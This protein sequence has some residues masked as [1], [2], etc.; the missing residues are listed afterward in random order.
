MAII[1]CKM[2]GGDLQVIEGSTV[3]ECEYCGTKQTVP[4]LDNEKKLTLFNRASRLL[5]N[6]EFD[7]AYGV[8]ESI[9]AEFPEEA[10][11][12]W[13]LCLCRYGIEYVDDPVT[14]KKIP[15]CHRTLSSSIMD[16]SDFDMACE[17]AD[18]VA[19]RLYR[20]E[21]KAIDRIQQSIL[22]I[23]AK[24]EPYDV[25]ICYKEL[26]ENGARTEDSVL[27][28]EIYDSLTAKG[29]KVFFSRITLES[30]LGEEYEP[31]IYAA[32]L[33][34]KVMLAVGTS[35]ENFDAVWVKNEWARFLNM[36]KK[37]PNKKL[38]PCFKGID[39]YDMPREFKNLLA[40]DMGKLGWQQDLTRGVVKICGK[41]GTNKAAKSNAA[42]S[43]ITALNVQTE[44]ML[45]RGYMML[46]DGEYEKADEFFEK[47]LN[48]DAE[49]GQAY[50]GKVLATAKVRN[51][52]E[53][54]HAF[55]FN[56][57][58]SQ[59]KPKSVILSIPSIADLAR[60][61]DES[62]LLKTFSDQ[63]LKK[64][65]MDIEYK[66]EQIQT[67]LHYFREQEK[68]F[69]IPAQLNDLASSRDFE[70]ADKY[71]DSVVQEGE[72]IALKS[73]R[74]RIAA[75]IS[76]E[77]K[78]EDDTKQRT[79]KQQTQIV[80]E[81]K[82]RL[83]NV[84][85]Y[86]EKQGDAIETEQRKAEKQAEED[87]QAALIE[88]EQHHQA[89]VDSLNTMYQQ[90]IEDWESRK[91]DYDQNHDS[92]VTEY[93][94]IQKEIT[95]VEAEK[96]NLHGLFTGK[97][98]REIEDKLTSLRRR[99]N[100]VVIP[101]DP[102]PKPLKPGEVQ[103]GEPPQRKDFLLAYKNSEAAALRERIMCSLSPSYQE[104]RAEKDK[105]KDKAPGDVLRFGSYPVFRNAKTGLVD[106]IVLE[107]K[108][109]RLLVISKY[110]ID[111]RF[112]YEEKPTNYQ[113]IRGIPWEKSN[114]RSWL[115]GSFLKT[116]FT[117]E[118]QEMIPTVT[119]SADMN[120]KKNT[121]PGR[122]TLDKIF[123]LSIPEVNQYFHS[124]A[125][126]K[127]IPTQY[128]RKQGCCEYNGTCWWWLRSPGDHRI[129]S[130]AG[131]DHDG[132]VGGGSIGVYCNKNAVRPAMWIKI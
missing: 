105:L 57:L 11:A 12:Y 19:K 46:E 7:K 5:R 85:Q 131:V 124:D 129:N 86:Y 58:K 64:L 100:D 109:N 68:R 28:Q 82:A 3:C 26:D 36:M 127:C 79:E 67:V 52:E 104:R 120:P 130:T 102:G 66:T 22:S 59:A 55:L 44:A 1:K 88:Y 63:E 35:Y 69:S 40:Q 128:A 122:P 34:A 51:A 42:D 87:Y 61:A 33:S 112:Y 110:G 116:A 117:E 132:S 30:K 41:D 97:R 62:G 10:E 13:G 32:L 29:L 9:V 50:W 8:F 84:A 94:K 107:K 60:K 77:E 114:L 125:E 89:V 4:T 38:I 21:A 15:T 17:N 47:V 31:Y 73:L 111:N 23:V 75:T 115:N 119:V 113:E 76:K 16:D 83:Q 98:K 101:E 106:W 39:A 90:E 95:W 72:Q 6:C 27:A 43:G 96:N 123:L 103:K 24:E 37:D 54:G 74:E 118:E 71:A 81:I 121:D 108:N 70:R 20:E 53:Y 126:R 93:E 78:K 18:A 48:N 65:L 25:F 56:I 80:A 45:K 92:A 91:R 14:A 99:L 2:C 49:C